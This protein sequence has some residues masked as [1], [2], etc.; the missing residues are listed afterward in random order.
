M[1]KNLRI[2]RLS[3][4]F[5]S[6]KSG[7]YSFKVGFL[8]LTAPECA[9]TTQILNAFGHFCDY[10]RRTA[11]LVVLCGKRSWANHNGKLHFHIMVNNFHPVYIVN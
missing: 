10:L 2:I 3:G 5:R 4:K 1:S 11:E 7:E 6:K 9:T 8:T